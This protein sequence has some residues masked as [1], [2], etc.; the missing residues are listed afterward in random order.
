M[1]TS[2]TTLAKREI[3]DAVREAMRTLAREASDAKRLVTSDAVTAAK[4]VKDDSGGIASI[5][6]KQVSFGLSIIG[7]VLGGFIFLTSPSQKNDVALQLQDQ[8]ITTQQT[9]IDTL[10]KTAQNDTQEVKAA[11]KEMILEIN[12]QQKDIATLTAIIN[13]RIPAKKQ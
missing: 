5:M 3:A 7:V 11:I 6:Y 9:T 1:S 13:E 12:E 10:T 2:L 8:R 4:V